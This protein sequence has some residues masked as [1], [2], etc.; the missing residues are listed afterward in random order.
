M[1]SWFAFVGCNKPKKNQGGCD[2]Q[3][4]YHTGQLVS[5]LFGE[6]CLHTTSMVLLKSYESDE[7]SSEELV[8]KL[9]EESLLGSEDCALANF[10]FQIKILDNVF[11]SNC[12]SLKYWSNVS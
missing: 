3:L 10:S 4:A 5:L 8:K 2:K 1:T 7:C 9:S 12:S 6:V 11:Q